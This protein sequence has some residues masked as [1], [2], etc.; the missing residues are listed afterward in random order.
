MS[1][2]IT[3][4]DG[5][6]IYGDAGLPEGET[7]SIVYKE[8][9]INGGL[10]M[11]GKLVPEYGTDQSNNFLRL[12]ENFSND[13]FPDDPVTGMIF[14]KN[15]EQSLFV[16]TD[17][18]SNWEEE[19]KSQREPEWTKLL[20]IQFQK[21]VPPAEPINGDL[22]FDQEDKKLYIYDSSVEAYVLIGPANYKNKKEISFF[23]TTSRAQTN[24]HSQINFDI[25]TT[26]LVTARIVASEK[27]SDDYIATHSG[28]R[29]PECSAWIYRLLVNNYKISDSESS[30][31]VS[32]IIGNP[33]FE[34]IGK[35][36]HNVSEWT[37]T[38]SINTS[39]QLVLSCFGLGTDSAEIRPEDDHVEWEID[40]DI[41]KV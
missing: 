20:A 6:K 3:K 5:T 2:D 17:E 25:G 34:L 19:G 12:L 16:C 33:N 8:S 18:D 21:P 23:G 41:V 32:K 26:N 37:V 4:T 36:E 9:N 7:D 11:I 22:F 15:D 1:Y 10:M 39:N 31:Y 24:F 35:T 29:R 40:I 13:I 14:Y 28:G 27:M 30:L 38:P